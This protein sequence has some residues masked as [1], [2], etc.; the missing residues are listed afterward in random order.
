MSA[1]GRSNARSSSAWSAHGIGAM[2]AARHRRPTSV[3]AS[4][5]RVRASSS[6]V[7]TRSEPSR[8]RWSSALGIAAMRRRCDR[9]V[10]ARSASE[11]FVIP[12]CYDSARRVHHPR[13]G[14]LRLRRQLDRP[15]PARRR[16]PRRRPRAHAG[17]PATSSSSASPPPGA[18]ASSSAP[19]DV[20]QPASLPAALAGVD[21][22]LHLVAIPRD[23][24]RRRGAAP[25][26][27]RGD[28]RRRR[29]HDGGRRPPPRPHGRDG[30]RG[31]PDPPL[32]ELEG[33][34]RGARRRVRAS[35]GRS[36]SRRSSSARA[37]GSSTSSRTSS[38]CRPAS[39][40]ARATAGAGSS[41][42]TSA[43]WRGWS[44]RRSRTR[45]RSAARSS[46]AGRATGPT[47]RSPR[48]VL[49]GHGQAARH[50]PDARAAHPL[51][52][53]TAETVRLPFPVATDQ[54]RQL[55][56]DNIG[57]LDAHPGA[58]RVRAATDGGRARVPPREGPRPA[59]PRR[60]LAGAA[61]A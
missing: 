38:G 4:I 21:A 49:R 34:G 61:P 47:A 50:R 22:V 31:R 16:P 46:W 53:G 43:T 36:S 51:V 45:P 27:H 3:G 18:T 19:G 20:T 59:H 24:P 15:G 33:E 6:A 30:R 32:R 9:P 57:P 5:P 10:V 41:R 11:G 14:R 48:E 17:V 58:V 2:S 44:S 8:W 56:L 54:L 7:S 35:T 55:R 52:A 25:R 40:G 28:A 26:Q 23:S 39:P 29:G 60:R 1:I 12:R 13:H 37:T 42:S